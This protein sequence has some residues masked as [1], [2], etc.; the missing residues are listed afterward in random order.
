MLSN[1]V[2]SFL[3][4]AVDRYG[5]VC[6]RIGLELTCIDRQLDFRLRRTEIGYQLLQRL[7][8]AR[9]LRAPGATLVPSGKITTVLP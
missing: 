7:G 3:D 4:D 1:V 6:R 2:Q 9:R 5:K 8:Q